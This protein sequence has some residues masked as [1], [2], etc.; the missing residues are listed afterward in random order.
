VERVADWAGGVFALITLLILIPFYLFFFLAEYPA[1]SRRLHDLVPP[2]Y[3]RQVDRITRDIG[4]E[5]V[6]FLRGRL[7]CG[8]LKALL[9][10]I[11]MALL[12][13]P[14]A[15]PIALVSGLLSLVP[16]LGFLAG[17]IP[18]S[19][20]ALTMLGGGTEILAWVVLLFLG[21]E[22]V[23]GLVLYPLVLGRETG[24][25]PVTLVV[26]LLAGGAL[27]GSL[28]VIVA[29]PLALICKVLWRELV[30]PLYKEWAHPEADED[31]SPAA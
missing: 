16:F 17:V 28:G 25:H 5:L 21:A 24:L 30:L 1:M 8:A 26:V 15:L 27:M 31:E 11:G 23:E 3:Q 22:G 4:R 14:Y 2:R 7:A 18:A 10:W 20:I 9:L 29:I 19:V 12:G 13:I 6:A